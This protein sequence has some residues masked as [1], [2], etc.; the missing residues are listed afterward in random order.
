[1]FELCSWS[2][3]SY[4]SSVIHIFF[5]MIR[6]PPRSTRTDT[7]LPY[8]TLFRSAGQP[9][10]DSSHPENHRQP[11]RPRSSSNQDRR[12]VRAIRRS[13]HQ[14]C[15]RSQLNHRL[16]QSLKSIELCNFPYIHHSCACACA[17]IEIGRA[18]W[19]ERVCRYVMFELVDV[20]LK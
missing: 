13:P 18:W 17:A 1:M 2:V 11:V 8:T 12:S 14:L 15:S 16:Q 6:R 9:Q 7:L 4:V 19:R 3:D 10:Q 5:L 20:S